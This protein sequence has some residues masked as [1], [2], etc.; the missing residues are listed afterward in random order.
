MIPSKHLALL[1]AVGL[2]VFAEP[3]RAHMDR[4]CAEA[5]TAYSLV[6]AVW[7]STMPPEERVRP[8]KTPEYIITALRR[9]HRACVV[10]ERERSGMRGRK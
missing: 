5:L 2:L 10:R 9:V 7:M 8:E 3:S 6:A 4:K 1:G